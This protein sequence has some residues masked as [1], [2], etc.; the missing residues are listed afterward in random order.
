MKKILGLVL[1][2]TMISFTPA[3]GNAADMIEAKCVTKKKSINFIFDISGGKQR[4]EDLGEVDIK[5]TE[6]S[7]VATKKEKTSSKIVVFNYKNNSVTA[8][9]EK[10]PINCKYKNLELIKQALLNQNKKPAKAKNKP[11]DSQIDQQEISKKLDR[12]LNSL[13]KI[14]LKLNSK[15]KLDF[16]KNMKKMRD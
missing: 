11:L 10:L 13:Y 5:F 15:E 4:L 12:I 8:N 2:I 6:N 7:I 16:Q 9:G 1:G 14:E 3:V